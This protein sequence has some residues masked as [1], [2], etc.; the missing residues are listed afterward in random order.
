MRTNK[1]E[2]G[3]TRTIEDDPGRPLVDSVLDRLKTVLDRLRKTMTEITEQLTTAL[4]DRYKI[5]RH[6][7]EGGETAAYFA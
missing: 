6:F 2:Q 7:G 1:D 3:R 5:E 4:A